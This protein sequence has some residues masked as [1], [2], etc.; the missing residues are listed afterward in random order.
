MNESGRYIQADERYNPKESY[1]RATCKLRGYVVHFPNMSTVS[2][3]MVALLKKMGVAVISY[4]EG[5]EF[6]ADNLDKDTDIIVN[7][8]SSDWVNNEDGITIN[9][10]NYNHAR[11]D[12][13]EPLIEQDGVLDV[14]DTSKEHILAVRAVCDMLY[15][16]AGVLVF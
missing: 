8:D 5:T 15:S 10:W 11:F 4:Y 14:N 2:A 1:L 7:S 13:F 6:D 9:T 16:T 3:I 12:E